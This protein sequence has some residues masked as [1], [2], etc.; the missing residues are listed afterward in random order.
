MNKGFSFAVIPDIH[1]GYLRYCLYD[2]LVYLWDRLIG[3][4]REGVVGEAIE[5]R[6]QAAVKLINSIPEIEFVMTVGDFTQEGLPEQLSKV[7]EI[8]DGL[9]VPWIPVVGNHELLPYT[10]NPYWG[11]ESQGIRRFEK[12]FQGTFERLSS[13]FEG[14]EKQPTGKELLKNYAFTHKSVRFIVVD[15]V[16]RRQSPVSKRT[17]M[18][19]LSRGSQEWLREQLSRGETRKIVFSHSPLV[20]WPPKKGRVLNIAGHWHERIRLS[21]GSTT[22]F[23]TS[24]LY[25]KP[26]I[27]VVKVLPSE[28]QFHS[29]RIP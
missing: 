8:L 10:T 6:L 23:I 14:W 1:L 18:V 28:I 2:Q 24:S 25:L 4:A 12:T 5:K 9:L 17:Q 29:E 11:G 15:N 16:N 21:L 13:V 3:G 26:V 7:K 22:T 20:R 19:F 27:T